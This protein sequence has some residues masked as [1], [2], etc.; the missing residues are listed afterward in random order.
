MGGRI[1]TGLVAGVVFFCLFKY[2]GAQTSFAVVM[3]IILGVI[4]G[5]GA[6]EEGE[7]I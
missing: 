1:F 4:S 7:S 3:G 2:A 6:E 5:V